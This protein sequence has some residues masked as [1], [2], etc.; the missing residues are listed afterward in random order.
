MCDAR[1][2]AVCTRYDRGMDQISLGTALR[3]IKVQ[4]TWSSSWQHTMR[5]IKNFRGMHACW[6]QY[7]YGSKELNE[8]V[9]RGNYVTPLILADRLTVVE[10][11][12]KYGLLL[13]QTVVVTVY[14]E[15][16]LRVH[17]DVCKNYV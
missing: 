1:V 17:E 5:Q 13:Q 16:R 3:Q 2:I 14:T 6:L 7:V 4:D 10:E 12:I 8:K 15:F 9:F 11:G